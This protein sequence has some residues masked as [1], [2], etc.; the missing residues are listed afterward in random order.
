MAHIRFFTFVLFVCIFPGD[1]IHR[2]RDIAPE[3][4]RLSGNV[5]SRDAGMLAQ[6]SSGTIQLRADSQFV[7]RIRTERHQIYETAFSAAGIRNR[8]CLKERRSTLNSAIRNPPPPHP[9]RHK[10]DT[11][12]R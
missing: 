2:R 11:R 7:A 1:K 8:G 5:V 4:E 3:T 10:L 9:N 12:G 6:R